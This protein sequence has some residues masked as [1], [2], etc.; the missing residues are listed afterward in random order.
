MNRLVFCI[1]LLTLTAPATAETL[2]RW[3]EA[4]GS[5][6]FSPTPPPKGVDFK[7]VEAAGN[8]IKSAE[9][10]RT[11]STSIL[12]TSEH[13]VGT[14]MQNNATTTT[15]RPAAAIATPRLSYA[16]DTGNGNK[17]P[18]RELQ[19]PVAQADTSIQQ[20]TTVASSTKRRQ[21]Q[22]LTKRVSSLERRLRSPLTA[23]D[24]DNTVVAMA[25]YQRSFDQHCI[26]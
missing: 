11:D 14:Q 9:P 26:E 8:I 19:Q 24:M 13:A 3:L 2:Y 17:A 6:T 12:A 18:P 4:D 22:D 25:R 16:P 23:D 20:P 15:A 7:K 21:C 5:I 10:N 1:I